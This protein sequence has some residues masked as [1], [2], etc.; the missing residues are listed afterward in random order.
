MEFISSI[1]TFDQLFQGTILFTDIVMVGKTDDSLA[2]NDVLIGM[3]VICHD[4]SIVRT[5]P[6]FRKDKTA[7]LI[8]FRRT[9]GIID[10]CQCGYCSS[11]IG[12]IVT[13]DC[14]GSLLMNVPDRKSVV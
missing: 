9:V 12:K 5:Q 1:E 10:G 4:R 3:L 8:A 13:A 14:S 2:E 11:G 7:M 6:V